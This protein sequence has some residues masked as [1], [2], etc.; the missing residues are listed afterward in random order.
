MKITWIGHSCFKIEKEDY[1]IVIDPYEDGSVPGLEPVRENADLVLCSHEHADHN[2]RG[3]VTLSG[4]T[5]MPFS[6]EKI[7]TWHDEVKGAKRG[8]NQIFIIDDGENRIAHLGD[9]GC[10]LMPDQLQKLRNLDAVMIPVGGFYTIDA[11]QAAEL[12]RRL[13]PRIVIPMHYR[14]DRDQYG[15]DVI[16]TVDGFT[17]LMDSVTTIPGSEIET[18]SA[19]RAQIVVLQPKNRKLEGK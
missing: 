19:R 12:V 7:S 3:G 18:A 5:K 14:S 2:F 17:E 8:N 10:E 13:K 11:R 9:L 15:Y 1:A 6:I 4:S 16:G